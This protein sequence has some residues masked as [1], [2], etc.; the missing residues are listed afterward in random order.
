MIA[1]L[2]VVV[3]RCPEHD[4]PTRCAIQSDV[5]RNHL[6]KFAINGTDFDRIH[7]W[8]RPQRTSYAAYAVG[9]KYPSA[10]G[11]GTYYYNG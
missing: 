5:S 9:F 7:A 10:E 4:Q 1:A 3:R 8:N 2:K 6:A 11:K